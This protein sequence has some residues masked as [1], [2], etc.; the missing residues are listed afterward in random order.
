MNIR[1]DNI[2]NFKDVLMNTEL[3]IDEVKF[4]LDSEGM[5]FRGLDKSHVSFISV[6]IDSDYFTDFNIDVPC[7]CICDTNELVKVLK[8]AK[9]DDKLLLSFDDTDLELQFING[10]VR[11]KFKIRQVDMVYDSPDKPQIRFP[12]TFEV[13]IKQFIESIKDAELYSDKVKLQTNDNQF[14]IISD[15]DLGD[16]KSNLEL[17]ENVRDCSSV[18]SL[19]WLKKIFKTNIGGDVKISMGDNMP[20]FLEFDDKLGLRAEFLLAPRIENDYE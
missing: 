15:G 2:K 12:E 19:E 8:R 7:S 5:R 20:L 14:S 10:N 4:E 16:Y 18:F 3:F 9:N 6:I 17:S 13:S 1:L 11:R